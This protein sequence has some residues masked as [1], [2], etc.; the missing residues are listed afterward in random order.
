MAIC[1]IFCILFTDKIQLVKQTNPN[2]KVS[3]MRYNIINMVVAK[4]DAP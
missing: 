1:F 4:K 3:L 2:L